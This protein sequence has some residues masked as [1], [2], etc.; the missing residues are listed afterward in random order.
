MKSKPG[1]KNYQK[2]VNA[3]EMSKL[4]HKLKNKNQPYEIQWN[5][6]LDLKEQKPV[7]ET[8]NLCLTE[9]LIILE[10][11]QNYINKRTHG[12]MQTPN[13][14]TTKKLEKTLNMKKHF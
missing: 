10:Q 1:E 9:A 12:I 2:Y 5:I 4:V 11:N 7:K 13:K 6:K 8:C 3:T 14:V